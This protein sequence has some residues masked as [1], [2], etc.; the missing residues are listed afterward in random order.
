M[1]SGGVNELIWHFA[2]Y[3]RLTPEENGVPGIVYNG[4][5]T[6]RVAGDDGMGHP[7]G[8]AHERPEHV[9]N[10]RLGI[11]DLV[12]SPAYH[13]HLRPI[14]KFPHLPAIH[15][16]LPKIALPKLSIPHLPPGGGGDTHL[17]VPVTYHGGGDQNLIYVSQVNWL[18][19]NNNVNAPSSIVTLND[20]HAAKA[21]GWM[22]HEATDASLD[23]ALQP[24]G[25]DTTSLQNWVDARDCHASQTYGP[26]VHNVQCGTTVNGVFEGNAGADVHQPTNDVLNN[27]VAALNQGFAGPPPAPTG[28]GAVESV[29]TVSVGSNILVN[30]AVLANLDGL[31]ASLVVG[32]DFYQTSAIIQTNVFNEQDHI[33]VGSGGGSGTNIS[34]GSNTIQNIADFEKDPPTLSS[35]SGTTPS[36]L[37]WTVDVLNGSLLDVHSLVQTN[38]I[39]NNDVVYQTTSTGIS[40]VITGGNDLINST[41]QTFLSNY[42]LIIVEGNYHQDD[43]IYQTN[44]VLNS[45]F[46]TFDGGAG[47]HTVSGGQ[48]TVVN[49]A[50]ITDIGANDFQPMTQW[51]QGMVQE[52]ANNQSSIEASLIAGVFPGLSGTAH[53]LIVT[54]DYYD[55]NYISQTNVLSDANVVSLAGGGT[56]TVVTGHDQ[57][58]NAAAIIDGVSLNTPYLQGNHYN[59]MILIQTNIISDGEKITGN[60][61][62]QLAPEL[63]AFTSPTDASPHGPC[64]GAAS[65]ELHHHYH[66]DVISGILH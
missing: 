56:Q 42:D 52:L 19:N 49:D 15:V 47:T 59:D 18:I 35:A 32:G 20:D 51:S 60:N 17:P 37:G 8:R 41:L 66:N 46:I 14:G 38:Y 6:Y 61:P 5:G 22:L 34:I 9:A 53:V 11:I 12:G 44:V 27:A 25:V 43:F 24:D 48:N 28:D 10:S 2:G 1:V 33:S 30:D 58:V 45:N 23:S 40:Q 7:N 57:V 4:A 50:S 36:G 65:G 29:H 31:S 39:S 16:H 13:W 26:D 55:I 62:N 3:L 63:V 54:G 64:A 21:L